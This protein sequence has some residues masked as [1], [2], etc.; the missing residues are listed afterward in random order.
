LYLVTTYE[1][2]KKWCSERKLIDR[3]KYKPV[4]VNGVMDVLGLRDDTN[5]LV[6]SKAIQRKDIVILLPYLR[7]FKNLQDPIGVIDIVEKRQRKDRERQEHEREVAQNLFQEAK[8]KLFLHNSRIAQAQRTGTTALNVERA[9]KENR[10]R[11]LEAEQHRLQAELDRERMQES[12]LLYTFEQQRA[13]MELNRMMSEPITMPD[14][15][16]IGG[17]IPRGSQEPE[18]PKACEVQRE[19]PGHRW[20]DDCGSIPSSSSSNDSW[21]S[22][23]SDSSSSDSGWSS[24]GSDSGGSSD[25]GGWD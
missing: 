8:R 19:T 2:F 12:D 1:G 3:L 11:S 7:E 22:S 15:Q 16:I 20:I 21:S 9:E 23:S 14:K 24:S 4:Y 25:S 17:S 6:L 13:A 18:P 10:L 5:I